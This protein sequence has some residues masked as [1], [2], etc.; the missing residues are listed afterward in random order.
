MFTLITL[1]TL[2]VFTLITLSTQSALV[3]PT[4]E[5][6]QNMKAKKEENLDHLLIWNMPVNVKRAYGG[7]VDWVGTSLHD[8]ARITFKME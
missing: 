4:T 7:R 6:W 3:S 8:H 2:V 5:S 1:S